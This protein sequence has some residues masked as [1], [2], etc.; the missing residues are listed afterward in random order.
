ML[1]KELGEE[2]T[3]YYHPDHLGSVS[4]VSNHKGEPYERVEYLPF[5][6]VWIEE[7]D[8][9]TGYIP[10]RFTSKEYDEET[11]LYYHG[12]RY[13]EPRLSRWMSA[14]PAGFALI[15]PNRRGHSVIEA[16]NWYSYTS[17]NPVKYV[18]PTGGEG[19]EA[20]RGGLQNQSTSRFVGAYL[21]PTRPGTLSYVQKSVRE[22]DM[23]QRGAGGNFDRPAK[24]RTWCNQSTFDVTE[25]MGADISAMTG[26][27][28]R[29]NTTAD[30][31]ARNLDSQEPVHMS[32]PLS[33]VDGK[34]AQSLANAG[35]VVIAAWEN[36]DEGSGHLAT[37][38]SGGSYSESGGPEVSNVGRHSGTGS[39]SRY[40]GVGQEGGASSLGD[41]KYYYD[42]KQSFKYDFSKIAQDMSE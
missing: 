15:N 12:A 39:A 27:E 42:P 23:Y 37:V 4:V 40:F 5:G 34:E 19:K 22:A 20:V 17:N 3:Y 36:P 1:L 7:T 9:A 21:H 10:F 31:A 2:E 6:E 28:S 11:G 8:P 30:E 26:S 16:A 13:Y 32:R 41:I 35:Y 38:L 24:G 18:D 14:D 29:W 33:K 25:A